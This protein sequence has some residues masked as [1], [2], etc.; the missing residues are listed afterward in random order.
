LDDART[1]AR[2]A[3]IGLAVAALALSGACAWFFYWWAHAIETG[4]AVDID[5]K[6]TF[7]AKNPVPEGVIRVSSEEVHR[8]LFEQ[9]AG[10]AVGHFVF[11]CILFLVVFLV[12]VRLLRLVMREAA[13]QHRTMRAITARKLDLEAAFAAAKIAETA[14]DP[15]YADARKKLVE[16]LL[17]PSSLD[18]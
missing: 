5:A 3:V 6:V 7:D 1:K 17:R 14:S 8:T 2:S 16:R 15:A 13:R 12:A 10:A 9:A 11:Y 4:V 18:E